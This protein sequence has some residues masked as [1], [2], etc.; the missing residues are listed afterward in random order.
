V[1]NDSLMKWGGLSSFV[2]VGLLATSI[3]VAWITGG[4]E[5]RGWVPLF[6]SLLCF[7]FVAT[8]AG[9]EYLSKSHYALA[10]VGMG[11]AVFAFIMLFFEAAVW[12]ADREFLGV[13]TLEPPSE[14]TSLSVL[15][16]SL[17]LYVIWFVGLWCAFWGAGFVRIPGKGRAVGVSMI[18]VA[19]F[20][21]VDY[22][23]F[24]VG[25]SGILVEMWH[26]GGQICLLSAFSLL[27]LLMLDASKPK[28][29]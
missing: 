13:T 27:G 14:T 12:G 6:S 11:F 26:L 9:Y 25:E 3:G 28:D 1:N 21:A 22:L 23:L 8:L 4:I 10:R 24:R 15:F 18:L 29:G 19:G 20:N 16:G 2:F 5:F 17:N 7:W